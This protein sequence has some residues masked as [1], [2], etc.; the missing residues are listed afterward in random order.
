MHEYLILHITYTQFLLKYKRPSYMKRSIEFFDHKKLLQSLF[1]TYIFQHIWPMYF[2]RW[3]ICLEFGTKNQKPAAPKFKQFALIRRRNQNCFDK[4]IFYWVKFLLDTI[5]HGLRTLNEA[6]FIEIQNFWAWT[7][8][9]LGIWGIF[10]Q[11]ISTHFGTMSPLSMFF[12]IQPL[13]LQ[14]PKPNISF[15]FGQQRIMDIASVCP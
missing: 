9:F 8:K 3:Y 6:F 13:I 7:D 12:I 1:H 14:K 2:F 10:G 11:T 15:E 4:Y 5:E